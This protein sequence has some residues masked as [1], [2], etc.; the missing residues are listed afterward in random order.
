[1]RTSPTWNPHQYNK[2]AT[3]RGRPFA[4]LL[5]QVHLEDRTVEHAGKRGD[6]V[7]GAGFEGEQGER[8][9]RA[10]AG[11]PAQ[12]ATP[13]RKGEGAAALDTAS[14][15]A[16]GG[17]P[18][19]GLLVVDLGCGPG[20]LTASLVERW[21]GARVLGVD[22]SPEMIEAAQELAGER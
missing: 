17:E 1:M 20:N 7:A 2:Y 18:S 8:S 16:G 3:E 13:G 10:G 15:G 9:E 4:D 12:P 5:A 19:G 6:A 22:S 11:E 21:P 14:F